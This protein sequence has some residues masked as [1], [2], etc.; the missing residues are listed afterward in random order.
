V[1]AIAEAASGG[2]GG[3]FVELARFAPSFNLLDT[4]HIA[5]I[6]IRSDSSGAYGG[7]TGETSAG[8]YQINAG[9]GVA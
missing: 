8:L 4:K 9:R 5:G 6:I 3:D 1:A 7:G 2:Q